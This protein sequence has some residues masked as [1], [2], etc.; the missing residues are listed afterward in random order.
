MMGDWRTIGEILGGHGQR[1]T[2]VL[3]MLWSQLLALLTVPP[4]RESTR[5]VDV[6][7]AAWPR[8]ALCLCVPALSL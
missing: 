4:R 8:P 7:L 3:E 1:Q 2:R 6:A 5:H